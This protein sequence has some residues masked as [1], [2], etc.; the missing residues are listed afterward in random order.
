MHM[1][2]LTFIQ[3]VLTNIGK[4]LLPQNKSFLLSV[5][6]NFGVH[7]TLKTQKQVPFAKLKKH[8][9]LP[10]YHNYNT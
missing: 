5:D 9:G 10:A 3:N 6:L 4:N 7:F 8:G 2:S 1:N